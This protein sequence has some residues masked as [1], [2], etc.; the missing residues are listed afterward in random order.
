M[1]RH[2]LA[3]LVAAAAVAPH[4]LSGQQPVNGEPV[5]R[6]GDAVNIVVWRQAELSGEALVV[7]MDSAIQH[8]LYRNVKVAGVPISEARARLQ[9]YLERFESNPQ[10]IL[11]P[12]VRVVVAGEVRQPNLYPLPPETTVAQAVA[13]AGGPTDRGRLDRVRLLRGSRE[14]ILDLTSAGAAEVEIQVES[15]DRIL[16]P[17]RRDLL[18][19]YVVPV[20]SV[21]GAVV[22]ILNLAR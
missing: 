15:G 22:S 3:L 2:C 16:I 8:P 7:G 13:L 5:L 18:R 21:I 12:L 4:H 6:P 14:I 1:L 20:A 9:S 19:D 10:F 11:Q 17:Y